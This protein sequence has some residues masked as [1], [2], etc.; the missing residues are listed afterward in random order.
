M[1]HFTVQQLCG[2]QAVRC[3][4]EN[5]ASMLEMH[6]SAFCRLLSIDPTL[7]DKYLWNPSDFGYQITRRRNFF[8]NYD[9]FESIHSPTLVCGDHF[10]PLLRQ[11]GETVPFAL[12]LRG[13]RFPMESYEPLGHYI[14]LMR[15]S[16]TMIFGM[17][18]LTLPNL[19]RS[20]PR[21]FL[22]V[23]GKLSSPSFP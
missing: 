18:R 7:P 21:T 11:N 3:L 19:W 8:R 1:H 4:A 22:N 2:P 15:W 20:A 12:L 5:A 17:A 14:N 10:G 23:N 6:Y 13:T 9:D 16:G